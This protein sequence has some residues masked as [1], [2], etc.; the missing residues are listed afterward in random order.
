MRDPLEKLLKAGVFVVFSA[1]VLVVSFQIFSRIFFP[2]WSQIWTEEVTRFLF[3]HSIALAAPLAMKQRDYVN[4]DLI[5][6]IPAR[7]FTI[8]KIVIDFMVVAL[9]FI[10]FYYG[11]QFTGLGLHQRAPTIKIPIA[12]IYV[13]IPFMGVLMVYYAVSNLIGFIKHIK[14]GGDAR[15][16]S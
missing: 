15:T 6:R 7:A 4:I 12:V 10:I 11:I 2:D 9:F 13:S 16:W 8:V 1:L 5:N 3:I 14:A